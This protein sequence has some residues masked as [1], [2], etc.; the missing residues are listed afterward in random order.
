[1]GT[2]WETRNFGRRGGVTLAVG[3][4]LAVLALGGLAHADAST[5]SS[6]GKTETYRHTRWKYPRDAG[7]RFR[8]A[9]RDPRIFVANED[10]DGSTYRTAT[11]SERHLKM[12]NGEKVLV[13]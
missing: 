1:M 9:R 10:S 12:K 5:A 13:V 3:L 2:R 11:L 8:G 6:A 7:G 4:A